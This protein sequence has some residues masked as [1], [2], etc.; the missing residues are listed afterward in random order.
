MSL[1]CKIENNIISEPQ[2]LSYYIP[3]VLNNEKLNDVDIRARNI[4]Q[5]I[6]PDYDKLI[7]ETGELIFDD[8]KGIVTRRII[9]I[10]FNHE[11]EVNKKIDEIQK[12]IYNLL[13]ITD[14]YYIRKLERGLDVPTE[15]QQERTYI[16]E[17]CD[18]M[19]MEVQSLGRIRNILVYD[20][21][22]KNLLYHKFETNS[23]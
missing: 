5:Y 20:Y 21:K 11:T 19:K 17:Q 6:E 1:Y 10:K 3:N 13:S 8:I 9:G 18:R 2:S 4:Y 22:I 23:E 7:Q 12:Y 15:I 14:I 16:H